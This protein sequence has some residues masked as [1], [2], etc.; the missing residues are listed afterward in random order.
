MVSKKNKNPSQRITYSEDVMNGR[1]LL[2]LKEDFSPY[3]Y[4]RM[5]VPSE[6]QHIKKS[7]KTKD[8][9]F[10][11][12]RAEQEVLDI[13]QDIRSGKQVFGITLGQLV[14]KYLA[15]RA[16]D[17]A[18]NEKTKGQEGITA[19]RLG[20]IRSQL[21][22]L[23]RLKSR[24][25]KLSEFD[26]ESLYEYRQMRF[27]QNPDISLVSIR[28]EIATIGA[29]FKFAYP[30]YTNIPKLKFRPI[31]ITSQMKKD[32]RRDTFSLDEMRRITRYFRT[33][34][35]KKECPDPV[36]RVNRMFVR[37]FFLILTNT[38]MRTGELK[39]LRWSDVK[40]LE[41]AKNEGGLDVQLITLVI[42][43]ET[44][45]TRNERTIVSRGGEYF[46]RVRTYSKFLEQDDFIFPN[47]KGTNPIDERMMYS[48]WD[49]LMIKTGFPNHRE[50]KL[51]FYSLRHYA[52]TDRLRDLSI[53]EVSKLSGT[54]VQYIEDQYGHF[55]E[56]DAKIAALKYSKRQSVSVPD[57][58]QWD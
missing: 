22:A 51:S 33:W 47:S 42:R 56:E 9:D 17:V 23:L 12:A 55:L 40:K 2:Y 10:A 5:W 16:K 39:Q 44:T 38:C 32:M 19:E 53:W 54:G 27:E 20:T 37:D 30:K 6:G 7:L 35:S 15:Y 43:P 29:M 41:P 46:K 8:L 50:R 28:N 13:L 4:L 49:D 18:L 58:V 45:K 36:E 26:A 3:Y 1:A 34:V 57:E 24:G 14:E 11:R 31:K 52:I 48:L 25:T 21:N